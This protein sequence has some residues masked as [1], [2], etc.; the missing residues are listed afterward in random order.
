MNTALT[1]RPEA[2]FTDSSGERKEKLEREQ[3]KRFEVC[4]GLL[5]AVAEPDE[6]I[7]YIAAAVAPFSTVEFLTTGWILMSL[8]RCFLVVT[9][10]RLLHVPLTVRGNAKRSIAEV[11]YA[12]LRTIKVHGVFAGVVDLVDAA[13]KKE[14]FS[15]VRSAEKKKLQSLLANRAN[16]APAPSSGAARGFL[17]PRCARRW[18]GEESCAQCG[19][20]F[21]NRR[22]GFWL[23][24]LAPGGGYFYTGHPW[25]GIG[26]ALTEIFLLVLLL[27]GIGA[28]V[29]GE[30]DA[31]PLLGIAVVAL[32]FEKVVSVYHVRHY[33]AEA[34]PADSTFQPG[35]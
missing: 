22:L 32:F 4:K 12:A 15:Q 7:L 35:A 21:K 1:L 27:F 29:M 10:R 2:A 20:G 17:C 8:K 33:L 26:D 25:L 31:A 11:R 24:L 30:K 23:A 14:R 5:Q 6:E 34:L 3:R 19:L 9:D 28:T 13:G 16:P 18:A